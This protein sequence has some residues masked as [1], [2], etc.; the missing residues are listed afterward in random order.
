M[1]KK[2][3]NWWK[4]PG[5]SKDETLKVWRKRR[6]AKKGTKKRQENAHE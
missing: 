3:K 2:K 4:Y 6:K 1:A 5:T